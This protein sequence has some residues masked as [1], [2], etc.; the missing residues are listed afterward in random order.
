MRAGIFRA[1]WGVM[2]DKKHSVLKLLEI[3]ITRV[4]APYV[5][6][7]LRIYSA[8]SVDGWSSWEWF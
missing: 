6:P 2:H 8:K 3:D 7:K 5:S 4:K 1:Y